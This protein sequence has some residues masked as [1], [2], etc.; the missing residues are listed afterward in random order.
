MH[1]RGAVVRGKLVRV[2]SGRRGGD[3]GVAGGERGARL[4]SC[5]PRAGP[6]GRQGTSPGPTRRLPY[7]GPMAAN[8]AVAR[9]GS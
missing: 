5:W 2:P 1:W 7:S 4:P 3:T 9:H 6:S 8:T